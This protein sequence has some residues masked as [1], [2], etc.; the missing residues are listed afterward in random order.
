MCGG[1]FG[2]SK[3]N[4]KD[5]EPPPAPPVNIDQQMM[6]AASARRKR[7]ASAG[8]IGSTSTTPLGDMSAAPV[9]KKTLGS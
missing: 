6:D 8:G 9:A 2:G 4:I 1:L 3:P 7:A 5:P